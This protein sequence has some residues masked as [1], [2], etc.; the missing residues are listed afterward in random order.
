MGDN[1]GPRRRHGIKLLTRHP[2]I[3]VI[4]RVIAPGDQRR[5]RVFKRGI[6]LFQALQH[7]VDGLEPALLRTVRGMAFE[8]AKEKVM[9]D[10]ALHRVAMGFDEAGHQ[11]HV[12]IAIIDGQIGP[13]AFPGLQVTCVPHGQHLS[14]HHRDM[15]GLGPVARHG[16]DG[17]GAEDG[18]G[19]GH[20]TL[21]VS[22]GCGQPRNTGG[23]ADRAT[24]RMPVGPA[25]AQVAGGLSQ[26]AETLFDLVFFDI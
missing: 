5:G 22:I 2:R 18:D 12:G 11:G 1:D 13:K 24:G 4:D 25:S 10:A 14:V 7:R 9:P 19:V 23:A 8:V 26:Q 16:D 21:R 17:L 15:G 6:G 20:G 3:V